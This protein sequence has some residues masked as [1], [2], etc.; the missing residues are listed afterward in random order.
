MN[1]SE[2]AKAIEDMRKTGALPS[3]I[4][5]ASVDEMA[6]SMAKW[7]QGF[8]KDKVLEFAAKAREVAEAALKVTEAK[9]ISVAEAPKGVSV[10]GETATARGLLQDFLGEHSAE[11][12]GQA[13]NME[14]F[15]RV[16]EEI[17]QGAG[18]FLRGNADP[19]MVDLFPGMELRRVY[20]RIVPR[21]SEKDPAGEENGWDYRWP[22]ACDAAGDDE[23]SKVFDETGR[24]VAL[25]SSDVWNQLGDGAGGYD[26]TLGNPFAPFAF[27]SGYDTDDVSRAECEELGLLGEDDEA[28]G[29]DFDFSKLFLGSEKAVA[30]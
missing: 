19:D 26:D 11:K 12:V 8:S 10:A 9:P 25:K 13:M 28:E 24:M 4:T 1:P 22:E 21:G 14:F 7:A 6:K 2:I 15:L 18:K 3:G 23:A 29:M 30:A 5:S 16:P 20:P 27:N 17:A